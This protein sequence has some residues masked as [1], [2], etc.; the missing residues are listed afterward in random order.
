[1]LQL[2]ELVRAQLLHQDKLLQLLLESVM[3]CNQAMKRLG[4]WT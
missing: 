3:V 1:M 2:V 4:H